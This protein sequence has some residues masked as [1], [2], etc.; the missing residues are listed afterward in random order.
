MGEGGALREPM[1]AIKRACRF[2]YG[3]RSG[4]EA[5]PPKTKIKGDRNEVIQ[6]LPG[7]PLPALGLNNMHG[8]QFPVT[9]PE[10][11]QSPHGHGR[12]VMEH[13]EEPCIRLGKGLG[14]HCVDT[15]R[16]AGGPHQLQM[17]LDQGSNLG[18]VRLNF[19]DA[20][21]QWVH[22]PRRSVAKFS[23]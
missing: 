1:R 20:A 10:N 13:R 14:V 15:A 5:D 6:N 8:L 11:F 7:Q 18:I 2:K 21:G 12:I 9:A 3:L 23:P 17:P 22:A 16:R 19:P 4:L